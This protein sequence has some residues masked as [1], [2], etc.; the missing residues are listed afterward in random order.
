VTT[1][2]LFLMRNHGAIS[3]YES[4]L[5]GLAQRGHRVF[6]GSRGTERH[7]SVDMD[8]VMG[9]LCR[10]YPGISVQ[11]VP[12]RSDEWAP[13]AETAR[14]VRNYCRYLHPR[15]N[16]A[17]SLRQRAAQQLSRNAGITRLPTGQVA[18][19]VCSAAAR[20]VERLIPV[21]PAIERTIADL[22]PD[23]VVV[24]PLVD[25]NSYQPDYVA[26]AACL[27]IPTV[28]CVASWD[29][30]S[31]KGVV[32]RVPDRVLVWNEAQRT[33]AVE[34][35]GVP[36]DRVVMTGAQTFDPW[37]EMSPS[38]TRDAFTDM[39]GLPRGPFLLYS[40]SS[41]FVA[42]DEVGYVRQW[43]ARVRASGHEALGACSV[44]VRP[45]PGNAAQWESV[46]L[47]DPRVAVWPRGGDLPL[48]A[49]AKQRYFDSLFHA[50]AVVGVNSSS[51]IEAGIVGRR[52]F[53]LLAPEFA[54]SQRGTIHF[55]YLTSYGF[56]TAA[57]TWDDHLAQV[58][59]ALRDGTV[60]PALRRRMM[61]FVRPGGVDEPSTA[62]VVAAIEE[63]ARQRRQ[64]VPDAD[65]PMLVRRTLL[66]LAN[67]AARRRD[68]AQAL[69]RARAVSPHQ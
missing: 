32:A 10:E 20:A 50:S 1:R 5:R 57:E 64:A 13:L 45:H 29:N 39:V 11:R 54:H 60:D 19:A 33:E 55:E 15:F 49:D 56:L 51:M 37:F 48:E 27:G 58:D 62:K 26:A 14:A 7:Y 42:P 21:D 17:D 16:R 24:T 52:C 40:C 53:T 28:W 66:L 25:F 8:A 18:G 65:T 34:L 59:A 3:H 63:V 38:M 30:L 6:I 4:T 35:Q 41:L 12:R 67:A 2:I 9:T 43:L 44:L 47:G 61:A 46:D 69:R 68:A 36:L 31:N 23:V 22:A